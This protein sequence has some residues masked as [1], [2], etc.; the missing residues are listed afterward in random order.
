MKLLEENTGK[1]LDDL[2]YSANQIPQQGRIHEIN[3]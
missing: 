2:G 3:N 1:N